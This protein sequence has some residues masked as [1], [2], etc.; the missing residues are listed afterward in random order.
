MSESEDR[1]EDLPDELAVRLRDAQRLLARLRAPAE[2]RIR[3]NLRLAAICNSLKMP[4][5]SKAGCVLR[6]DQLIAD[7]ERAAANSRGEV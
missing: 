5:S 1:A 7:A 6:L 3:L 2:V 4:D